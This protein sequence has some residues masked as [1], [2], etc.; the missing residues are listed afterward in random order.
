MS[1]KAVPLALS[2]VEPGEADEY[3]PDLAHWLEETGRRQGV[4]PRESPEKLLQFLQQLTGEKLES[5]DDILRYFNKLKTQEAEA[6]EARRKRR[7]FRHAI[8]VALLGLAIGQYYYWDV[9]AQ[10]AAS[11]RN[12]YF[13]PP[14]PAGPVK[15]V[16]RSQA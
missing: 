1:P 2:P 15:I 11:Q 10:I 16:F 12:Y 14:D 5:A 7:F 4:H 9:Q 3:S 8:L 6:R 13:G